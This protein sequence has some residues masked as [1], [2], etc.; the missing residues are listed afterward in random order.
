MGTSWLSEPPVRLLCVHD[1]I[2]D[3]D[4]LGRILADAGFHA[5]LVASGAEALDRLEEARFDLV[6]VR[7]GPSA[8]CGAWLVGEAISRGLLG[9]AEACIF[10]APVER[11]LEIL[12][13]LRV[14]E[15]PR[16]PSSLA[17]KA[18]ASLRRRLDPAVDVF[19]VRLDA[20][21]DADDTSVRWVHV[22]RAARP[23]SEPPRLPRRAR[24][25][26]PSEP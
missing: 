1:D 24:R 17:W 6:L 18:A 12:C 15:P 21:G 5:E 26:L 13:A 2:D 16:E 22:A 8:E 19:R 4:A 7:H 3:H 23:R 10:A 25:P 11:D 20:F 9:D 14:L